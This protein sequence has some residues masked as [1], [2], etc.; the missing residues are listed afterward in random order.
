MLFVI[1][2]EDI[3]TDQP[4]RLAQRAE[5]MAAHLAY[6]ARHAD[7]LVACGALRDA[8]EGTPTGGL[9]IAKLTDAQA[10]Q[11]L[12]EGDPFWRAGLRK[13]VRV[14]HWAQAFWSPAFAQCM[15]SLGVPA[16]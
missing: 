14:H 1:E 4:E 15:H 6:L 13:S 8:P 3:Y 12:I 11:A 16:A 2:F 9:W 5:H 7:T 10:A